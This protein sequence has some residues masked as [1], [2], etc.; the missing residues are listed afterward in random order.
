MSHTE[1]DP[2]VQ[3]DLVFSGPKDF[4]AIADRILEELKRRGVL[5]EAIGARQQFHYSI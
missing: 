1:E 5:A 4:D 3:T 2:P